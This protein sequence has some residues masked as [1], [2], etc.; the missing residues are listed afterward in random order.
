M[1][2]K[3]EELGNELV[4]LAQEVHDGIFG[5]FTSK[6]AFPKIELVRRLHIIAEG[7]IDG[8]YDH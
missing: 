4:K 3:K 2:D 8:T 7:V 5:D 6:V 1:S